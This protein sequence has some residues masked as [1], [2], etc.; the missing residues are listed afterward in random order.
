MI[1]RWCNVCEKCVFVFLL[2]SAFLPPAAVVQIFG[3]N[4][5]CCP[6]LESIFLSVLGLSADGAKPFECIG[7]PEESLVALSLTLRQYRNSG[8]SPEPE[9]LLRLCSKGEVL[10]HA[11]GLGGD[12]TPKDLLVAL[13]QRAG[14]SAG[15]VDK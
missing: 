2:M 1:K 9:M 14:R 11:S 3:R 6:E 5:L 12:F 15:R 8:P 13:G 10:S 7:T 4:L